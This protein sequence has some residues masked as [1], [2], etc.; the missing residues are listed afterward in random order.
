MSICASTESERSSVPNSPPKPFRQEKILKW[1]RREF[2]WIQK[3][4]VKSFEPEEIDV[5]HDVIDWICNDE[6]A[7]SISAKT[8]D[9][10]WDETEIGG[11]MSV[12][13]G[14]VVPNEISP[15][16]IEWA[17]AQFA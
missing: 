1:P 16:A 17:K 12:K 9:A 11:H 6:S 4:D 2:L 3:P 7:K 15:E 14:A 5:L 8:H 13:A 10:L